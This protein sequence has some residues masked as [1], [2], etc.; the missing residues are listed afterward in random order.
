MATT[1]SNSTILQNLCKKTNL[2]VP[3]SNGT[4]SG[5][6]ICTMPINETDLHTLLCNHKFHYDCIYAWYKVCAN[7]F[8]TNS[9]NF[10]CQTCPYCRKKGGWLPLKAG[11]TPIEYI[12][13]DHAKV[14]QPN[15]A[16]KGKGKLKKVAPYLFSGLPAGVAP[17]KKVAKKVAK[18][19]AKKVAK[20]TININPCQGIKKNGVQCKNHA[21][22]P[23]S[24]DPLGPV[25]Y[26]GV[27]KFFS[28][29]IT[30][31]A[32]Y[33]SG[34][35]KGSQCT[36]AASKKNAAGVVK[37]CGSHKKLVDSTDPTKLIQN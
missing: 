12:N 31:K 1:I 7:K 5:C 20:A 32:I 4:D 13:H 25:K 27:H 18:Q 11:A 24:S 26:C 23:A 33:A 6:M 21:F 17:A 2:T 16:K 29:K 22:L 19:V 8:T 28:P 3:T 34:V 36:K 14:V 30:C 15:P 9:Q 10:K 37:C 35:N